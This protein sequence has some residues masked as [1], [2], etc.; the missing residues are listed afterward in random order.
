MAVMVEFKEE[1]EALKH[2]TPKQKFTYFMDYYKW[3]V[4]IAVIIII[5]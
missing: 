1:R 4:I 3:Y 5:V 2:G